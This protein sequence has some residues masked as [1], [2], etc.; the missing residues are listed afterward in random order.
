ME[1]SR[2][3]F[4]ASRSFGRSYSLQTSASRERVS[5]ELRAGL[6]QFPL[7]SELG[8]G[9]ERKVMSLSLSFHR[10]VFAKILP[11]LFICY[12]L[13]SPVQAASMHRCFARVVWRGLP[14]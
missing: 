1:S 6:S 8:G 5:A 4:A 7:A 9:L 14:F 12:S 11:P 10:K 2:Q 3:S 13:S